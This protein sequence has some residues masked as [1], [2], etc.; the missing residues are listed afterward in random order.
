MLKKV[1]KSGALT[2]TPCQSYGMSFTIW[3]HT[4]LPV[5]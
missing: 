1:K 2:G 5:Y 3:D 4:V